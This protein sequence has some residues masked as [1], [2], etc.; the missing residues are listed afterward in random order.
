M[1]IK[2]LSMM[3]L[4]ALSCAVLLNGCGASSKEAGVLPSD[5]P[6]VGDA[7]C[8]QCHSADVDA[9]TGVGIVAQYD[10]SSPHKDSPHANNGN[11]CEACHGGGAQHNG[12]GPIPYPNPYD[13]NGTRCATC[14][15]GGYATNAPTMF[16]SSKHA[17]IQVE[18]ST[19]CLRCHSNEGAVLG[20]TYGLTGN[21]TVMGN[22][23]YQGLVPLAKEYTQFKCETCHQ[24]G[25]GLRPVK[26]HD[27][28]GNLVNWNPSGS[29]LNNDQFNFCTSCHG[30]VDNDRKH[31]MAS[32]NTPTIFGTISTVKVGFHATSWYRVIAT[33]HY[34]NPN[35]TVNGIT[36]YVIRKTGDKP[37]F[38]CHAHEA[39]T[40]TNLNNPASAT[41]S[42]TNETIYTKWA[43]S[44]H[45][46][47]LLKAKYAAVGTSSNSAALVD[48]AMTTGVNDTT[49]AAWN[50]YDW[51]GT[52]R[53][54]CQRCHTATGASNF[55]SNPATYDN[56]A[57][58]FS[59]LAG[60]KTSSKSSNQREMLYCWGCHSNAGAGV[61]RNPG[62]YTAQEYTMNGAKAAYPD[63]VASNLCIAC[64]SGQASG[65]S[66][67]ALAD[68]SMSNVSFV[69]SHYMAAAGTMYMKMGFIN[70]TSLTAVVGSSTYGQTLKSDT[71]IQGGV[72][73][74]HRKLGTPAVEGDDLAVGSGI[75]TSNGPC[76]TCHMKGYE[77]GTGSKHLALATRPG[78]GHSLEI[79]TN[80][81]QQVCINCHSDNGGAA[82]GSTVWS[83][84]IQPA[85]DKF[86]AALTVATSLLH[87]NFSIDYDSANY[88]YFFPVG[89]DHTV[90]TNGV[91]DW[92]RSGALT[93]AQAKKLMGACFNINML[94]REPG[95]YIHARTYSQRL[96]YD[97]IDFLDDKAMNMSVGTTL[98]ALGNTKGTDAN[99]GT[100]GVVSYLL[101][102][103]HGT[104]AW[105]SP[106]RP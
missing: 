31:V 98:V 42:A 106:E 13:G 5:V 32:G 88:P 40:N 49:A 73:S 78:S 29:N 50:H 89:V 82:D 61:L 59:H 69:N 43:S 46:G 65:E 95:A 21:G 74:W 44:G 45:A 93:N 25:A 15:T 63:V 55:L 26:T 105:S 17:N 86:Q 60:W 87:N 30:L 53:Q 19:P 4:G 33:T 6:S 101:N 39:K 77:T 83:V 100:T 37:C 56:T 96:L 24:H 90:R 20:A 9:L 102:H 35:N 11:G 64:H 80:A 92:T 27:A 62:A 67:T 79:D 48:T 71:D 38:D 103:N 22:T 28:A 76:V 58:D 75:L 66:I 23:T 97:T 72:T 36:G 70:F 85:S 3:L 34:N 57:N 1:Q 99:T 84:L 81:F 52:S 12:V 91:T 7:V 51:S 10:S 14:H 8:R 16:A 94:S 18:T 47:D 2:K 104:G 54:T 41:Y 68:T